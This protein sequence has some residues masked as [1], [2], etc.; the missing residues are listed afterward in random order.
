MND[1]LRIEAAIWAAVTSG[2]V[3]LRELEFEYDYDDL[4]R[5]I[6]YRNYQSETEKAIG[7]F[8]RKKRESENEDC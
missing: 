4:Q 8:H 5:L 7:E 1:S 3:S 6:A 2:A